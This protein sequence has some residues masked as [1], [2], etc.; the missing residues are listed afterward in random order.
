MDIYVKSFNRPYLLHRCI[1][2]IY[3]YLHGFNGTIVLLDDGTPQKYLDKIQQL[4]PEIKI[5]KSPFYDK[6]SEA[7]LLNKVPEKII[8]AN[9]WREEVLKGSERFVL[10]EDDMWF[11]N[12]IDFIDFSNQ[13]N[14][15]QMDMVKLIW[16]QNR[17]LISNVIT[18]S[19]PFFNHTK[20]KV[21]TQNALL[22][23]AVFRTNKW[24]LGSIAMRLI[25]H[26][27]ALLTYYQLYSVAGCVFS[28]SYYETCWKNDQQKVDEL[29][30]ISQL[31]RSK[32]T[33]KV[34]NSAHEFVRTS[35]KTA[36]SLISKDHLG[37]SVDI[38][39]INRLL[40]ER[41]LQD[42]HYV[43][44]DF[45]NNISSQWIE[46]IILEDAGEHLLN[47]WKQWYTAFV[48]SYRK[49]GCKVS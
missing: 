22:F 35:C 12:H 9:F 23:D 25:D 42:D 20:P 21:L 2:S 32:S 36:A 45:Q 16:L 40:N 49:I 33:F 18:T 10:I 19:T 31:L 17:A 27:A 34:G 4:Y 46:R 39:K 38:F 11:T 48:L 30:Q 1:A 43:I 6:K 28:K 15:M 47:K 13:I 24:K 44:T 5:K 26:K 29:Q 8:P 14:D 37:V 3:H 41:W 7:I